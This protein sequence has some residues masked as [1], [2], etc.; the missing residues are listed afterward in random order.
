MAKTSF[1]Y[2][3][4]WQDATDVNGVKCGCIVFRSDGARCPIAFPRL[5]QDEVNGLGA[6]VA[7]KSP[8]R[9]FRKD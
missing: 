2:R 5:T 9:R 1:T 6:A 4:A 7:Q 3:V 8:W